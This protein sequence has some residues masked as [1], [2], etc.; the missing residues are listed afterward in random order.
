M[1]LTKNRR[2]VIPIG[3]SAVPAMAMFGY[4]ISLSGSQVSNAAIAT[5]FPGIM[6]RP[7]YAS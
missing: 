2:D 7:K 3:L 5:S 4:V 6:I 1:S